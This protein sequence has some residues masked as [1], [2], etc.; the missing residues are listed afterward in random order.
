MQTPLFYFWRLCMLETGQSDEGD[1]A[2]SMAQRVD[3]AVEFVDG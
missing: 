2:G 1:I 3:E